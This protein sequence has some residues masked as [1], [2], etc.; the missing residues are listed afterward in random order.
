MNS[1][2]KAKN[3]P[4][5]WIR[6]WEAP[7]LFLAEIAFR[8]ADSKM[9]LNTKD[10]C[11]SRASLPHPYVFLLC[12]HRN[13]R[14]TSSPGQP[15]GPSCAVRCEFDGLSLNSNSLFP[16]AFSTSIG[17]DGRLAAKN[18]SLCGFQSDCLIQCKKDLQQRISVGLV[19]RSLTQ[20]EYFLF[21]L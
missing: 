12:R 21:V 16:Y 8:L 19:H 1:R 2:G 9:A 14:R 7:D 10:Y 6:R 5:G 18:S 13:P 4:P 11:I 15:C 20:I 17:L 3:T